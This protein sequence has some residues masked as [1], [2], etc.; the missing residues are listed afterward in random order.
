MIVV[1][2][3]ILL[4]VLLLLLRFCFRCFFGVGVF[5]G[6]VVVAG[7]GRLL[8]VVSCRVL[9]VVCCLLLVAC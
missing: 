2:D 4:V 7:R 8:V 3:L 6:V 9:R 5:V 1:V